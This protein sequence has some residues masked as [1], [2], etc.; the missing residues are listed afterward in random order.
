[1]GSRLS[2]SPTQ[3]R[4]LYPCWLRGRQVAHAH[5]DRVPQQIRNKSKSGFYFILIYLSSAL[6]WFTLARFPTQEGEVAVASLNTDNPAYP[7]H[8]RVIEERD[9]A[10]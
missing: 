4:P 2:H 7:I 9:S 8:R 6:V 3:V 10:D 1:M 5:T